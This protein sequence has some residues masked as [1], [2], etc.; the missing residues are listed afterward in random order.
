VPVGLLYVSWGLGD[1]FWYS[2]TWGR[3]AP[4][5]RGLLEL[6][7][8]LAITQRSEGLQALV[9]A[10]LVGP[11]ESRERDSKVLFAPVVVPP[12]RSVPRPAPLRSAVVPRRCHRSPLEDRIEQSFVTRIHLILTYERHAT[13]LLTPISWAQCEKKFIGLKIKNLAETPRVGVFV[14]PRG[15]VLEG[16]GPPLQPKSAGLPGT[17]RQRVGLPLQIFD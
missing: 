15:A 7:T 14:I 1:G 4:Q 12:P 17:T 13:T 11:Y 16:R 6:P 5:V 2:V 9:S 3:R 10:A 8:N